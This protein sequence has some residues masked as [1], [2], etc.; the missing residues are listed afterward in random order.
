MIRQFDVYANPAKYG[1]QERPF[2]IVLQSD[3]LT[4]VQTHLVAPL[5]AFPEFKPVA[6]LNPAF[7][8]QNTIVYFHPVEITPIPSRLLKACIVNL[9]SEHFRIIA[10]IDLVITGF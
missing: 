7:K 6:R 9:E 1:R 5:V 8:V 2:I 4:G 3:H 10:A